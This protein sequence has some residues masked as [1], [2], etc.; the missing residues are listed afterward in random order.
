[1]ESA[2]QVL[3]T[4]KLEPRG[5][6]INASEVLRGHVSDQKIRHRGRISTDITRAQEYCRGALA[7][8]EDRA[9]PHSARVGHEPRYPC[10]C[11]T[12]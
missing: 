5:K 8:A 4:R 12:W 2:S 6:R 1:M 10:A 7:S 9:D 3:R 11:V